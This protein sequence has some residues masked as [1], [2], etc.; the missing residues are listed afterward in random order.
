MAK[1]SPSAGVINKE[2]GKRK[3]VK[4]G[5]KVKKKK[6]SSGEMPEGKENKAAG[7]VTKGNDDHN[8]QRTYILYL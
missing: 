5:K 2:S 6:G 8:A 7:K 4:E 3:V 1:S